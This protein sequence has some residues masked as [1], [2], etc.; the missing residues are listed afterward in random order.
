M[1]KLKYR[2]VHQH[3]HTDLITFLWNMRS[4]CFASHLVE[5]INNL[6]KKDAR[7][8]LNDTIFTHI[9]QTRSNKDVDNFNMAR[10]MWK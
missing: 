9:K 2:K 10:E 3:G 1:R 7:K 6:G 5:R 8:L 4:S